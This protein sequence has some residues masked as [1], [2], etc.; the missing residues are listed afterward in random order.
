MSAVRRQ[1]NCAVL[2]AL[3]ALGIFAGHAVAQERDDAAAM[4][5]EEDGISALD[6]LAEEPLV[7]QGWTIT[8][9]PEMD[10]DGEPLTEL[11]RLSS[12]ASGV[13][14][15]RTPVTSRSD[16]PL[17]PVSV[18]LRALDKI[19]ATYT[20]LEVPIGETGEFG[21]LTLLPRT[22]NKRPPD[23]T[24]ETTVFL[25][26]FSSA[27]DVQGNRTRLARAEAAS[28]ADD[29]RESAIRL[30]GEGPRD[31]M[32][33]DALFK[34]WMFA[35]SPSLNAMEHPVYDVWVIDCK[36]VDPEASEESEE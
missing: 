16:N 22:C 34:G 18:T 28:A 4:S 30:P 35:S 13:T 24:P 1:G 36:M 12:S 27:A 29:M 33:D 32:S 6:V 20:D 8:I 31:D 23:E 3:I 19:T 7:R 21:P 11:D 2:G 10:E 9:E 15:G 5:A 26:V 17:K 14:F 25:E